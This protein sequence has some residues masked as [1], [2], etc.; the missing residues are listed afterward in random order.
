VIDD[1]SNGIQ[2][3]CLRLLLTTRTRQTG[4]VA[5]P[6]GDVLTPLNSVSS[7][8]FARIPRFAGDHDVQM[9]GC[10]PGQGKTK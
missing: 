8:L 2:S 4:P 5:V 3:R 1:L 10:L 9:H 6:A 7:L